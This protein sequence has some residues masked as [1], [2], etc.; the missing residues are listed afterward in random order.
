MFQIPEAMQSHWNKRGYPKATAADITRLEAR[1]GLSLPAPYVEFVTRFGF[2][3]FDDVP[4]M[5]CLFD[6]TIAFPDRKELRQGDIAFLFE[7]DRIIKAHHICTTK[8]AEDEEDE[9]FPKFP[10]N[11]LP[12][13]NDAGQGML[14]LEMG[15]HP[16]R[17]W[18]W[19]AKEWAWGTEDNTWLG[20]VAEDFQAFIDGL[21]S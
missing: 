9:D 16:G 6:Y 11:F 14:L 4:G 2:V 12:V 15:E 7:P 20:F 1:F 5:R 3:V 13:G 18:Y 17:I 19:T 8:Q 10:A 21:R